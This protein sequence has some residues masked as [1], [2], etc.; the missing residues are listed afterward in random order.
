MELKLLRI[1]AGLRQYR[2][3]QEL[4]I[5]PATLCDWENGRKPIPA[6]QGQRILAVIDRLSL[7]H[8][9]EPSNGGL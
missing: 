9:G 7:P 6:R 3:A 1:R 2:V 4:G 5:P 8:G